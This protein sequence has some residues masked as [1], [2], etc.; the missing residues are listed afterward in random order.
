MS[1]CV[2]WRNLSRNA[3]DI[4]KSKSLLS[5]RSHYGFYLNLTTTLDTQLDLW[6]ALQHTEFKSMLVRVSGLVQ[7]AQQWIFTAFVLFKAKP[8]FTFFGAFRAL[9]QF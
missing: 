7:I 8:S 5:T 1:S 3:A 6:F 9:L 4:R 2:N